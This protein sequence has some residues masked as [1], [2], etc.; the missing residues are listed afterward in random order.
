MSS[1]ALCAVCDE[2]LAPVATPCAATRRKTAALLVCRTCGTRQPHPADRS[3]AY[4]DVVMRVRA[5]RPA[6]RRRAH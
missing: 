4:F 2:A 6:P 5:H 3:G 1:P